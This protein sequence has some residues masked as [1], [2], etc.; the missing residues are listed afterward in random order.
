MT[1]QKRLQLFEKQKNQ[2][3]EM[4]PSEYEKKVLELARKLKI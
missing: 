2:I 1:Y 3:K 4:T